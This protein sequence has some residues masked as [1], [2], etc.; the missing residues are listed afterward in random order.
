ML[1][2]SSI[3]NR[4]GFS[5][6]GIPDMTASLLT[7]VIFGLSAGFAPGPLLTLV[8]TQTLKHNIKE[9]VKVALA[10]LLTDLPIILAALERAREVEEKIFGRLLMRPEQLAE[11][12]DHDN[13]PSSPDS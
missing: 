11:K 8:I 6:A 9:G 5:G 10:P 3:F 2:K 7:G 12:L 4:P 13:D 1:R